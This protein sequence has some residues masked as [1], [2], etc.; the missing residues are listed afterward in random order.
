MEVVLC[1]P[2]PSLLHSP[3]PKPHLG[4]LLSLSAAGLGLLSIQTVAGTQL[5][6]HPGR[7][8]DR[9]PEVDTEVTGM[10]QPQHLCRYRSVKEGAEMPKRV[11][12]L[13]GCS[14]LLRSE[15]VGEWQENLV[16][17]AQ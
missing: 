7:R 2:H 3:A 5:G 8:C 16:Q 13:Q 9:G 1:S 14:S 15:L 12:T 17:Y 6:C 11:K 4:A 10:V